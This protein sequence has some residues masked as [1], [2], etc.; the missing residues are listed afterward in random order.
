MKISSLEE[1]TKMYDDT[2]ESYNT[3]M[4]KEINLPVYIETLQLLDELIKVIPGSLIDTSCGSGQMLQLFHEK[5]DPD[6][7]LIGVDISHK[8]C[9]ITANRLGASADIFSG[10]MKNLDMIPSG[11]AAALLSYF[12][13][14]H[15]DLPDFSAALKEW[16]RVLCKGGWLLIAAWEGTGKIDYGEFSDLSAQKYPEQEISRLIS[17][18]G[19]FIDRSITEY[20]EDMQ[21]N[22]LYLEA[23]KRI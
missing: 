23:T 17:E 4:D 10:D 12:A 19:F 13:L 16:N 3:M 14:H 18:N 22:A 20:V 9:D 2:A 15:L 8:M 7:P 1:V 5:C 6:R 11:S 21:M